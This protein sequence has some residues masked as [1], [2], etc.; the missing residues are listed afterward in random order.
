MVEI[1]SLRMT[2]DIPSEPYILALMYKKAEITSLKF[3]TI[4][5]I[6]DVDGGGEGK[7]VQ[8]LIKTDLRVALCDEFRSVIKKILQ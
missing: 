5:L 1:T 2:G 4:L 8:E 3:F 6:N 7:T